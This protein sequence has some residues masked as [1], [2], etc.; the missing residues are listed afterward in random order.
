[1]ALSAER[2]TTAFRAR[3]TLG[4]FSFNSLGSLAARI[5]LIVLLAGF[6]TRTEHDS[7]SFE[8]VWR[9]LLG[10]GTVPLIFTT[11]ARFRIQETLA[12]TDCKVNPF[13][14]LFYL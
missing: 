8:W 7:R 3:Q 10:L 12:Y 1:V 9:L 2:S 6:K 4:I 11:Y 13:F 5:M 14:A